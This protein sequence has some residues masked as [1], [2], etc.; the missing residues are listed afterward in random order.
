MNW[1]FGELS[2]FSFDLV[3]IDPPTPFETRSAKGE[4]KSPQ[5]Q[6]DCMPLDEIAAM[7]VGDLLAPGGVLIFWT[8]WPL[9][10]QGFHARAM[11][12]YGVPPVTGGAWVKR[13]GTGKLRWGPG[14]ILRSVC[15]PYF[16]G[17]LPGADTPGSSRTTNLVETLA[18]HSSIDGLAREHSRKPPEFY[19]MLEALSPSAR[20]ADLFARQSRPGWTTWGKEAGK[21]DEVAA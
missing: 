3:V 10:A 11:T 7:P 8:T 9:A 6:Y 19:S 15:E 13:T 2:P 16:V 17:R 18:D 4:E 14:Y 5:A 1:P 21:F 12:R 20:R